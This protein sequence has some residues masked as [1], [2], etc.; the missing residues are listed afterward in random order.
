MLSCD[1]DCRSMEEPFQPESSLPPRPLRPALDPPH[2][3]VWLRQ[4]HPAAVLLLVP[5]L[6]ET[7]SEDCRSED[8]GQQKR[9][10]RRWCE[11]SQGQCCCCL[12]QGPGLC[13]ETVR[14]NSKDSAGSSRSPEPTVSF[15]GWRTM[16][17]QSWGRK[18]ASFHHCWTA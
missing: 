1:S 13:G 7:G 17:L 9:I 6:R 12:S 5:F 14:E 18:F 4:S 8:T 2:N 3:S 16:T 15:L 11:L 10:G